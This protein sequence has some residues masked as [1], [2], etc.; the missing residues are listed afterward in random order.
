ME[1][2]LPATDDV[3]V[4]LA[5][6]GDNYSDFGSKVSPAI[7]VVWDAREDV[8][9]RAHWSKGFRAPALSELY[10]PETHDES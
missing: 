1:T 2:I 4:D 3:E 7:G 10:G 5:L 6:R 8:K 9:V